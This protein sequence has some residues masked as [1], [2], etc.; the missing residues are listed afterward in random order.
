MFLQLCKTTIL[1]AQ[2]KAFLSFISISILASHLK[3]MEMVDTK[4]SLTKNAKSFPSSLTVH[5]H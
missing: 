3:A 1:D 4:Q 2:T 5:Q